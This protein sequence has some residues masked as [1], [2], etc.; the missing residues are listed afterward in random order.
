M[1][2]NFC[3]NILRSFLILFIVPTA[4]AAP[5]S[6][7]Y[8][9]APPFVATSV[10]KPNVVIALDISGSMKAV[11]YRDVSAGGWHRD[12]TIHDD[13]DPTAR[14]F[15]YFDSG[16]R[17]RYDAASN[18][19]FFVADASGNWDGN[20]LNWLTMRRM[21][22]V[23]KVLVGGKVRDRNG[24]VIDGDTWFVIEGQN[25]PEDRT[26][27]KSYSGSAA[28]SPFDDGT[29]ILIA[30]GTVSATSGSNRKVIP[31]STSVEIGELSI[32][33]NTDELDDLSQ[34]SNW[35]TVEFENTY[36]NPVVV[37]T[38]LSY[39]GGDPTHAR[40]RNVTTT[41]FE[42][43]LE[44]WDYRDIDH[45]TE[46]VTYVVAEN[47]GGGG[48][49]N[50]VSVDGISYEV[51]A[52]I[53]TTNTTLNG[54]PNS[55]F[56]ALTVGGYTPVIFAGV[57]SQN[58]DRPVIVRVGNVGSGGFDYALQNEESF[59]PNHPAAEDIHWIAF[60]PFSGS[61]DTAGITVEVGDS[62]GDNVDDSFD[63]IS[64]SST[65][66]S[67]QPIMAVNAQTF[68]GT[69]TAHPRYR[70]VSTTNFQ[71]M[72]EEEESADSETGHTT[73]RIGYLA[74]DSSSGYKIQIGVTEEPEGII[75]E[76]SGSLRFGLAVYNYDHSK[77][78]TS[79]YNGNNVH[80][81]TFRAC[82]PDISKDVAS[83]DN[84]DICYDTHVKSPLSNIINVIEDHPLIWGTTPIAETLYEIKGYF[85][86]VDHGRNGHTQWYD[87]G[88][89]GITGNSPFDGLPKARN[90][91]EVSN[92][93]DPYYY[94]EFGTTL[95]CAKS[96]VLHFNDGAPYKDFDVL[97]GTTHPTIPND[98]IGNFGPQQ[99][100]DD[101]ALSLRQNDC[102]TEPGM[103]GHQEIISYYVFAAL[104]EDEA[105]DENTRKMREAALNGGFVDNNENYSPDPSE[106]S[107]FRNYMSSGA[108]D[109]NDGVGEANQEWDSDNDCN[110]D[111][112]YF[113]SDGEQLV[114]ELNA[115]FE[116]IVTRAATGGASSVIAASR[117]GEGSVVNA[118]FRPFVSS[119]ADE[120][121]WIGD[122]HA[123]MIDDAGHIRQDNGN[124]IL[125]N[126][127]SDPYLDMCSNDSENIVR[128]KLSNSLTSRPTPDQYASCSA[129]VFSL[130]LFDIEYLWSGS[131]WLS[132]LT[133][134]D[135][136]NQRSYTSSSTG[137][138]IITGIDT[139][140]DGLILN[141]EQVDFVPAS[142]PEEYAGLLATDVPDAHNIINYI[143]GT[144]I[145]GLRSRQL[146]G[147]TM[148]LGDVIYSTPTIVGRPNE[149][150]DLLYDS[151]SYRTFFNRYR[152]RRQV[153]YAG[154]N[155][156]MLHA[157]NGGWYDAETKEFLGAKGG[158][159]PGSNINY[160]L[161]AELWAYVPYNTLPHLEYLTRPSYGTVSSDHLYF[162]D[163]KPRIFD[164]RIFPADTDHP[165]GWGTVLVV[166][167]RLGGGEVT[168]DVDLDPSDTDNR[169][170]QSSYAIFD[171][172]NPDTPPELLL[173]FSHPNLGFTTAA[174]TPVTVGTDNEGNG[175]WYLML[176][177]G[178]D[179]DPSGFEVVKSTQNGRIFLLDLKAIASGS[180]SVL[181][182]SFGT[183][184]IVTL[185][186]ANSFVS[187]LVSVDFGLDNFTTDT[188]YFGTVT[189]DETSWGGKIN[190]IR[191]QD[192]TGDSQA[193][194]ASWTPTQI[195]D[196]G[197]PVTAP[198]A[199]AQDG[200]LN[201][202]L[203][204]GT[205]RY[206]TSLD[207]LNNSVNYYYGIKEPRN[208]SG[209]YTYGSVSAYQLANISS[210][211]VRVG[212][213]ELDPPPVLSP[214]LPANATLRDLEQ[215]L[216]QYSNAS[217]YVSG[218]LRVFAPGERNFG[219][220]TVLGGTLTY[221]TYD[222]VFDECAV[223]G[224]AYLYI[225]NALT[226]T[227]S[228]GS[229]ITQPSTATHNQYVVNIGGSP[230]TS[231]SLHRGEGYSTDNKTTAIVQTA[232]GNIITIEQD[233]KYKIRDGEASW[234]QLR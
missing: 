94:D 8:T 156:G 217:E 92:D 149:N 214:A 216:R 116:D 194:V 162:V 211:E 56:Q 189:G 230:A 91:Y 169:T 26:F 195:I 219:A 215:R 205:G 20:F 144:D 199:V 49:P 124:R 143:R 72:I 213:S 75:Q 119:G 206:F 97:A 59:S 48:T 174:P 30:N 64:F 40:I 232:N 128:A 39:N 31:L 160:Q 19:Q 53:N 85:G 227:A 185:S 62:G 196:A 114:N 70:N 55:N 131:E 105:N 84:F 191:I 176:G 57:S 7:N 50:R 146:N 166:G 121:T 130:D 51:R 141:S 154:G 65:S 10:G 186:D 36:T 147:Q 113:A 33:R 47:T 164:A 106:P 182:S 140:N 172:T 220:A 77:S 136:L 210:A 52:G 138:H 44:E 168:V 17:Y 98:G 192:N 221:T 110:P 3:I 180:T 184:G 139:N 204:V 71:A 198:V 66:F 37:A 179:T 60:E 88:K 127:S 96:F 234:R 207:N 229:I 21:D 74:V 68:N 197:E 157:F 22:V 12:T 15:G 118:I 233:N 61:S 2:T 228:S 132:S 104:G 45:T 212:S 137:R 99:V 151:T 87:N 93:W 112:F 18:K 209:D 125:E 155:D 171:I 201:R 42:V 133:D 100:L 170:L 86:Q 35:H 178:A 135:V 11:A 46:Q 231:P 188:V 4:I 123:L 29:Q 76:N 89:E 67:D 109:T 1:K 225:V 223:E 190:R 16:S 111:T 101:L 28:L 142:F 226:G 187:D 58:N 202:W 54:T 38:G 69:D 5:N 80:G 90:S 73:E 224:D 222:P 102:R 120:V 203:Y 81:G 41:S 82:Y 161:G 43:R 25:E 107:N 27:R 163:L 145:V 152:N 13:F 208:T 23:R 134:S 79:I 34:V 218:W 9:G 167:M 129:S 183:G 175:D 83:R 103:V 14:Y 159:A 115:A 24:E 126:A 117:S 158:G 32:D 6:G 122:V 108:C 165:G 177:S 153:V 63:T 193:S 200:L 181:E 148:R 95:P 150:L 173:E 78:P